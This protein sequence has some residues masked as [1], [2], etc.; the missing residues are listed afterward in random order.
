MRSWQ[1]ILD[2][3]RTHTHT[4]TRALMSPLIKL[5]PRTKNGTTTYSTSSQKRNHVCPF[6]VPK[7]I[8]NYWC[9]ISSATT[10][11]H[12]HLTSDTATGLSGLMIISN[13]LVACIIRP[14]VD[15]SEFPPLPD[16]L[17]SKQAS[18]QASKHLA[19]TRLT[20]RNW[21]NHAFDITFFHPLVRIRAARSIPIMH[22]NLRHIGRR[23]S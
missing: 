13:D 10:L 14:I 2:R 1:W 20:L 21:R 22:N 23:M 15:S 8:G 3:T 17:A 5:T 11:F 18:K 7:T 4:H 19:D 16:M 12:S 6:P 9:F